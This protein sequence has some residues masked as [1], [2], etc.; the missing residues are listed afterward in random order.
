MEDVKELEVFRSAP[1][2]QA[3]LKNTVPA[4]IAML[5]AL[6]YNLADTL[7]IGMTHDAYQIAA[8]SMATP[9]FLLFMSVGTVFGIGG[10]SVIS[11]ALG[12]GRIDYAR[13]ACSFCMWASTAAG[14][15]MSF[16]FL[17][18]MENILTIMGTSP[19]TH[20]FAR[21]YLTIVTL[22]GPF[23]LIGTCFSS[24]LRAE[25]QA[26]KAMMGQLL[27]NLLNI[28]FDPIMILGFGWGITGAAVATILGNVFAACYYL[29]F[30]LRKKSILSIRLK[31]F[32]V[33][34]KICTGILAI[35][36][37]AS[38][39]SLLMSVSQ[40]TLNSQMASYGDMAVAGIGIACKVTMITGML[41]IGFG[42]GVQPVLGFCV[43]AGLWDRFKKIMRFSVA[44]SFGLSVLLTVL[45]YL[46]TNQIVSAFLTEPAAF[47][48]AVRFARILLSTSFLFGVFF[49]LSNS[50]QSAGAA[51]AALIINLSRQGFIF[52]PAL[53]FLKAL[54]G[55][56][57]LAWAQPAADLCSL[58][59]VIILYCKTVRR[60]ENEA[61]A[62]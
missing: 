19:D 5:M 12:E 52:I 35:G 27:G 4:M 31:D 62:V 37:P 29:S 23:A 18:F 39:G 53:F 3:V 45:C 16:L 6:I 44:F 46:F 9:V 51:K 43:G 49:V 17:I 54:L 42:Q 36:V 61:R 10:T 8:V 11:R 25:G 13:K 41:F 33:R 20:D 40:I 7:F 50:L 58:I 28:V 30:Y 60:M 22:S 34:E 26:G 14:L 57:G 21:S 2:P 15:L 47:G 55:A 32:T 56:D 24:V 59:L 1:V 38:L 48:Y